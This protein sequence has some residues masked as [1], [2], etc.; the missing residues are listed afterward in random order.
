M[1]GRREGGERKTREK[2]EVRRRRRRKMERE[3]R[4]RSRES[5]RGRK[6]ASESFTSEMLITLPTALAL[7]SLHY[8]ATRHR[9]KAEE[10]KPPNPMT[11]P[12]QSMTSG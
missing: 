2:S 9:G 10:S 7:P 1:T 4:D 3:G 5:L 6:N 12:R 8:Q 11:A